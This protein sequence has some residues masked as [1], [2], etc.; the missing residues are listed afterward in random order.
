MELRSH[1]DRTDLAPPTDGAALSAAR[2]SRG[3]KTAEGK[4]RVRM[5]ALRHG[6]SA[7]HV[8]I[9]G[10]ER[11]EDWE[12]H[13][14]ALVTSLAPEGALEA[15]LAERVAH[16]LWRLRRVTAYETHALAERQH[17][18]DSAS[19]AVRFMARADDVDR[20]IRYEAHLNRVLYHALHELEALQAR[21]H[22]RAAPLARL[23]VQGLPEPA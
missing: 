7:R 1:D 5:N 23:D 6:I 11:A 17:V 20:V 22:G 10:L 14:A 2:R 18:A 4:A 19:D 3:P 16:A 21:R 9:P 8:V 13:R 12:T 15:E